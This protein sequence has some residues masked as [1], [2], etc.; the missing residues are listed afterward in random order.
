M[1]NKEKLNYIKLFEDYFNF[2]NTYVN[3]GKYTPNNIILSYEDDIK[4]M[5]PLYYIWSEY[6]KYKELKNGFLQ[7]IYEFYIDDNKNKYFIY[8]GCGRNDVN[9]DEIS[10]K[11][12]NHDWNMARNVDRFVKGA[13]KDDY[14]KWKE[15]IS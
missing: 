6:P 10:L 14:E 3:D 15:L 12:K 7:Y 1:K 8:G 5:S 9:I 13:D 2:D 4:D 11:I